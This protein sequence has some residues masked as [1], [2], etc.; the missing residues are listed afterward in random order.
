[1]YGIEKMLSVLIFSL[2]VHS[3][4]KYVADTA[5]QAFELHT[6]S[7]IIMANPE[8]IEKDFC[9]RLKDGSKG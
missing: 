7:Q 1:M 2:A 4:G 9:E 6:K 8:F 5:Y 3:L